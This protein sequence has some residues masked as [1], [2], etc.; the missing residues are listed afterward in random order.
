M[1]E[2][3]KQIYEAIWP[4]RVSESGGGE[5]ASER[6]GT[7][8]VFCEA[9]I[10]CVVGVVLGPVLGKTVMSG[11]VFTLAALVLVG[12]L[13]INP[14]YRGFRKAGFWLA[15]GV[16]IGLSWVLLV[17]FFYLCFPVGRLF[18]ILT[19]RDPMHREFLPKDRTYW[20]L[21]RPLPEAAAYRR[22]Y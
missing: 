9:G 13:W 3:A 20:S 22:Q 6:P 10:M 21:H 17:P 5:A 12:G 15:K 8:R 16:G 2:R 4:W 1:S 19:R 7:R 14:L 11:I 18:L